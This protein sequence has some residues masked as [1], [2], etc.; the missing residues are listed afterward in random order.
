MKLT[1]EEL[2]ALIEKRGVHQALGVAGEGMGIEQN[3]DELA[4]FLVAMQELGV[5]SILKIGSDWTAGL[6]RFLAY[7]MG[8]HVM[9][10]DTRG[11]GH[12]LPDIEFVTTEDGRPFFGTIMVAGQEKHITFN[13]VLID[14]DATYDAVTVDHNC[15][16]EYARSVVAFHD[17]AGL[18]DCEGRQ[19]YWREIAYEGDTLK[20]NHY[21]LIAKGEQRAGLGWYT[22]GEWQDEK[23]APKPKRKPRKKKAQE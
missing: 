20:P 21:E 1:Y 17:I 13:L 12:N 11:Y 15:Y 5:R 23:P 4:H 16:H 14:A 8:W 10:V 6:E 2:K 18:R 7:D 19:Q 22:K 3:A 9:S